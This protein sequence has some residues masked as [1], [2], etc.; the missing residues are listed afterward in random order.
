M[1]NILF[2]RIINLIQ[3]NK[4]TVLLTAA[5]FYWVAAIGY[6]FYKD[7]HLAFTDEQLYFN[8]YA[9]NIA[10]LN[11]FSIDGINPTAFHP[12][13]YPLLLGAIVSLGFGVIASRLLNF[14]ALFLTLISIYHLLENQS[15]K[16]ASVLSVLF[17]LAYPVLFYTAG[18]LYPQTIGSLFLI[19]S[20]MFYWKEPFTKTNA[21]LTG[22]MFGIAILTIPTF[23]YI[24]FFLILFSFLF[25][26]NAL[27]KTF[28]VLLFVFIT[29]FPWTVRNYLVF[30]RFNLISTNFG[31]NFLIGNSPQQTANNGPNA[32]PGITHIIKESHDLGLDEFERNDFYK[33]KALELIKQDPK[34]YISLYF[35]KVVNHFNFRNDLATISESS[36]AKDILMLLTYGSLL[37]TGIIR[38]LLFKKYLFSKFEIIIVVLYVSYAFVSALVF[39]RIRYRLPFDYLLI[40]LVAIFLEKIF[41][42]ASKTQAI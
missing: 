7:S 32:L 16:I 17:A 36:L 33:N 15:W 6:S 26:K 21:V 34:H 4:K 8:D 18:T 39:P 11:L 27:M 9:Q 5:V 28:L 30:D 19:L 25:R 22:V 31:I 42:G 40:M 20:V 3:R 29:I 35:L 13:I 37:I 2:V 10:N 14:L 38:V 41:T 23:L 24:P 12:P 1:K